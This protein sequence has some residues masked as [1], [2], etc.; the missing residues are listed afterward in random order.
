MGEELKV[1]GATPLHAAR[2][3]EMAEEIRDS[4]QRCLRFAAQAD[5][6]GKVDS[7]DAYR[8]TARVQLGRLSALLAGAEALEAVER[9]SALEYCD[10]PI[11][12]DRGH[13][14]DCPKYIAAAAIARL[15]A[16]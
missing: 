2:L 12:G 16:L 5:E 4:Y 10:C 14:D 7:A 15:E 11:N 3:R 6:E 1:D 13:G 8:L 9:I